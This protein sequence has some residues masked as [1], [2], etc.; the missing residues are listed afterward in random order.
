LAGGGGDEMRLSIQSEALDFLWDLATPPDVVQLK[1][2]WHVEMLTGRL[3]DLSRLNHRK[4]FYNRGQWIQGHNIITLRREHIWGRFWVD[5]GDEGVVMANALTNIQKGQVVNTSQVTFCE[6]SVDLV[7][8]KHGIVD[9]IK[10][11]HP[12]LMIGKFFWYGKFLGYFFLHF[13]IPCE[14]VQ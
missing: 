5:R 11:L 8:E 14:E 12:Q 10:Q 1:G 6:K 2:I 7:Y 4:F 3:P 9:Q 13:R